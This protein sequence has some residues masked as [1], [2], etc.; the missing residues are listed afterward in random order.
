MFCSQDCMEEAKKNFHHS[1]ITLRCIDF[2]QRILLEALNICD[3]SFDKILSLIDDP[4]TSNKTIFDFDWNDAKKV[5]NQLHGLLAFSSLQLGP[6]NDEL[7]NVDTHPVLNIFNYEREKE[8][9]K[10]FMTR[11]AR[12][13]TVNCY[14]LDYPYSDPIAFNNSLN[15]DVLIIKEVSISSNTDWRN[16][17]R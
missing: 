17:F 4:S 10:A 8:I 6:K 9:A 3:G 14:S 16:E 5:E 13:L 11:I 15:K 12:I 1:K 2:T 7:S